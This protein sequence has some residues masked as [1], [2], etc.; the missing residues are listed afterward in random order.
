[1]KIAHTALHHLIQIT[2]KNRTEENTM[3]FKTI[4]LLVFFVVFLTQLDLD[5]HRNKV[6]SRLC[7][8]LLAFFLVGA[9]ATLAHYS[10]SIVS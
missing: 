2:Q 10:T 3:I 4:S 5:T 6:F 7:L 8:F 9:L 1:M